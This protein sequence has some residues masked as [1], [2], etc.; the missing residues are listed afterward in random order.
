MIWIAARVY[1]RAILRIGAPVD[2]R[3]LFGAGAWPFK[4]VH[5]ED[6]VLRLGI[7]ALLAGALLLVEGGASPM[8]I[9]LV[10]VGL[11]LMLAAALGARG[12]AEPPDGSAAGGRRPRA[13]RS[14]VRRP[15]PL[16]GTTDARSAEAPDVPPQFSG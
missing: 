16:H 4:G 10:V 2:V 3:S 13:L 15:R 11:V 7:A 1:E 5:D 12:Q 14:T 9:A 8:P 6:H